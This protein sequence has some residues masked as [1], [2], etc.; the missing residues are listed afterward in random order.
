MQVQIEFG[1][2]R[3]EPIRV[4]NLHFGGAI[5]KRELQL[6]CARIMRQGGGEETIGVQFSHRL[7]QTAR[8]HPS[9][10]GLR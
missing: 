6:V 8:R 3:R 4:V 2:Q 1:E 10:H 5:P 7:Q 9:V